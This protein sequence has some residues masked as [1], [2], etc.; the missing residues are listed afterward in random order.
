[1][2]EERL[3]QRSL[4]G[5]P[6]HLVDHA[7]LCEDIL[8]GHPLNLAFTEH[9]HGFIALDGPLRRGKRPTPQPRINAAF[10]QSMIRFYEIIQTVKALITVL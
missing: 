9:V 3:G 5:H 10:L 1:M 2:R 8:L 4:C 6:E 7:V